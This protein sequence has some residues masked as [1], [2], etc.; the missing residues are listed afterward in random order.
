MS[1]WLRS[2]KSIARDKESGLLV[3]RASQRFV[4]GI[5]SPGSL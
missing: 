4:A 5:S 1:C 2:P 3:E